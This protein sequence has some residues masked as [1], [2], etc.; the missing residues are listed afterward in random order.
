VYGIFLKQEGPSQSHIQSRKEHLASALALLE[1]LK[2]P[3]QPE[4]LKAV[5][6]RSNAI[7]DRIAKQCG[8]GAAPQTGRPSRSS[9]SHDSAAGGTKWQAQ[10]EAW[11]RRKGLTAKD[12]KEGYDAFKEATGTA[13]IDRQREALWLKLVM[14]R[15]S[16]GLVW[17]QGLFVATVGASINFLSVQQGLF[18]C[19]T[20]HMAYAILDHGQVSLAG[21]VAILAMQG[22]Q[23]REFHQFSFGREKNALLKDL[24]GNAFTG[25]IIAAF[26]IAGLCFM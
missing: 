15:K 1:R 12:L 2:V 7:M 18:P 13:L 23:L 17:Q 11:A 25:N 14:L 20:P 26:L 4:S 9:D 16:K 21:G 22:V 24:G 8:T 3:G 19:V 5:L 10:H 6:L